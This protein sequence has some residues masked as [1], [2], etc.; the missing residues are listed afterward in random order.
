MASEMI[1][2]AVLYY[3][4]RGSGPPLLLVHG[5]GAYA[6]IWS[7]VLDGLARSYRVIAYDRRGFA[8]SSSAPRGGLSEHA[9]DAAALLKALGASPATVVGWSGG[10]VIALDLAASFS[11]CVTALVLAE[12]AV[13]LTTH[14]S[15]GALAMTARSGF[16]RYVR[17]DPASAALA[18][19]QWAS[20]YKT[21]GNAFDGLP[22]VWRE[23]MLANAPTT[24]REMD[25]M[26]RPYPTRAAIRSIACPV[27][28]IEGDLSD[29]AFANADAFVMRLLPQARKVSLP[30]AAH[31][32]HIDQPENWVEVV[33][34]RTGHAPSPAAVPSQHQQSDA[35]PSVVG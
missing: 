14:P 24:L 29:P 19:Y 7:P 31:M 12:P 4:E 18:M 20:G 35:G 3:E 6:D 15:R 11:D 30:G 25:Q 2:G 23:Q 27:T 13:H 21:G 22:E 17:R 32:L 5:T 10:G 33:T 26:I 9:R 16:H 1:N 34:Q 28:V 8:R